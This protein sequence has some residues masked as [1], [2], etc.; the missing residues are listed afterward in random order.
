MHGA[1]AVRAV[2]ELSGAVISLRTGVPGSCT[3]SA[4]HRRTASSP[5]A[6]AA[7][8]TAGVGAPID[9]SGPAAAAA[10]AAGEVAAAVVAAG[11][12]AAPNAPL[13]APLVPAC[14]QT[15]GSDVAGVERPRRWGRTS[16]S[17]CNS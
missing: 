5:A 7:A 16:R 12:A 3:C 2:C 1:C 17:S 8:A 9:T 4:C 11:S 15:G 10:A 13:A 6:A 14:M